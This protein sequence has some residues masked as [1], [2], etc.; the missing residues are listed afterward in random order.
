MTWMNTM[1]TMGGLLDEAASL[2]QA[3][4]YGEAFVR[5]QTLA[6]QGNAQAQLILAGMLADGIGTVPDRDKSEILYERA[7]QNGSPQAQHHLGYICYQRNDYSGACSWYQS[8]ASHGYLPALWRLAWLYR[9]G[10]GVLRDDS[11]AYELYEQ[12]AHGGHVFAKRDLALMLLKGHKGIAQAF[13]GLALLFEC[14]FDGIRIA[15]RSDR[16]ERLRV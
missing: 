3:Q 4:R 7:A 2:Y 10:K 11:R 14:I 13:R 9:Q 12:A 1:D 15:S 16:D 8:S 5:Y 6:E